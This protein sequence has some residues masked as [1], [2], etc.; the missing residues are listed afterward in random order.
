[1]E[2][3]FGGVLVICAFHHGNNDVRLGLVTGSLFKIC[4]ILL[5]ELDMMKNE[6]DKKLRVAIDGQSTDGAL[7]NNP[8][9][10]ELYY[11]LDRA[12]EISS[13]MGLDMMIYLVSMAQCELCDINNSQK[14][15]SSRCDT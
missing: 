11:A 2:L 12:K 15:Q 8:N 9:I 1:L 3:H 6:N 14:V 13:E 7:I 4:W 5:G 10:A